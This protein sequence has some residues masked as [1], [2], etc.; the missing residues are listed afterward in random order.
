MSETNP[1]IQPDTDNLDDFERL[2]AGVA[3]AAPHQTEEPEPPV[4]DIGDSPDDVE[5]VAPEEKDE[6]EAKEDPKPKKKTVQERFNEITAERSE[7][8]RLAVAEKARA[9]AAEAELAR[10]KAGVKEP[11]QKVST[12]VVTEGEPRPDEVNADGE[13]KYPL[14]EF[15]PNYVRDL[16]RF[17]FR[18]ERQAAET[19]RQQA[20][21]QRQAEEAKAALNAQW[22]AKVEAV[23]ETIPDIREAGVVLDEAFDSIDPQYGEYLAT[24]IMTMDHGPE[25]LYYLANNIEI[26]KQIANAGP[27]NATLALG[28]LQ[29]QFKSKDKPAPKIT[30][31]PE[32][33][34]ARAR[35]TGGKFDVADDTDNLDAFEKK[36][37]G[38]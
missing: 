17:T 4:D 37:F 16:A 28:E 19:E 13:L 21:A 6:P 14:G 8:E 38:K 9:D 24:T 32:P 27:L 29:A 20:D 30:A 10:L 3:Q 11:E 31:A 25:V 26:A 22:Q 1:T 15:D 12:P 34:S 33:P 2:F 5:P 7:A 18:Q 36:F 35:G 23:K